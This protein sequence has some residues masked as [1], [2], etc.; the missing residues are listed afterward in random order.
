MILSTDKC[1]SI[2]GLLW[3]WQVRPHRQSELACRQKNWHG[4]W[5]RATPPRLDHFG[6]LRDFELIYY[7]NRD[8][9]DETNLKF[10]NKIKVLQQNGFHTY[11]NTFYK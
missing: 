11:S 6:G 10:F 1:H 9:Y 7:A 2:R 5:L 4:V 8:L 3:G